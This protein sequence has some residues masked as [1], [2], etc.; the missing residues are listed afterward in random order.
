VKTFVTHVMTVAMTDAKTE[1]LTGA[2]TGAML[3]RFNMPFITS[4]QKQAEKGKL[5]PSHANTLFNCHNRTQLRTHVGLRQHTCHY[6]NVRPYIVWSVL[7]QR[8]Y[9]VFAH[10]GK[11]RIC[12]CLELST[13]SQHAGYLKGTSRLIRAWCERQKQSCCRQAAAPEVR[14]CVAQLLYGCQA[15]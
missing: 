7:R 12:E 2:K 8:N 6:M 14:H 1:G 3:R 9:V 4:P 13:V 15:K 5:C 11:T 10:N